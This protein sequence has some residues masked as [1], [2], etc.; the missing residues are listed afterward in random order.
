MLPLRLLG[1]QRRLKL[2]AGARVELAFVDSR[3]QVENLDGTIKQ[4]LIVLAGDGA[5]LRQMRV[6]LDLPNA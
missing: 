2:D 4:D 3:S 1:R 5:R 6:I